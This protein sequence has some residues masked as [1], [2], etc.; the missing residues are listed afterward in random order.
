MSKK[1]QAN[2]EPIVRAIDAGYGL[3]KYTQGVN[4][5]GSIACGHFHS[6][7]VPSDP[8][9][10]RSINIRQRNTVDVSVNGAL[11]EVG[12]DVLLAQTGNDVGREIGESWSRSDMYR[13]LMLGALHYMN[14][15][16]INELVLG[17]PVNQYLNQDRCDQLATEYTGKIA[18]PG[19]RSV[20]IDHVVVRP[21]PFGGF[22]DMGNH[23]DKINET[24]RALKKEHQDVELAISEIQEA[25][26][27]VNDHCILVVDPGE[28]TL[29]WLLVDHGTINTKASNA[30]SDSGRQRII[31]DVQRE[32]ENEL[33]RAIAPANLPR[34]NEA[35]RLGK[36]LTLGGKVI[37][38]SKYD[39][40]IAQS[41]A[42]PI[43]RL[44]EGLRGLEDRIDLIFLV[45]GHPDIYAKAL[46]ERFPFTPIVVPDDTLY[47][48]V[49]GFYVMGTAVAAANE[50]AT[51]EA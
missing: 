13:A 39:T 1:N 47:A 15:D 51:Q 25:A 49:R 6:M 14:V 44:M 30:A 24:I 40:K 11:Y 18:L 23:L 46:K 8:A 41:V 48:N 10:M 32:L 35:L 37:D 29:D 5:D 9:T 28:H 50:G 12:P 21:Q 22:I 33:G 31:R 17:L 20:Q 42:D 27:L 36:K 4:P 38:L 3:M 2:Q 26:Q 34:I 7:A 43:S 19:G 45:G 16:H